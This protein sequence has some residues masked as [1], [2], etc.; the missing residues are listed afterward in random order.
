MFLVFLRS[1]LRCV[2]VCACSECEYFDHLKCFVWG[3]A[4]VCF[5]KTICNRNR[6]EQ[7][8]NNMRIQCLM[9][10]HKNEI[11]HTG[12]LRINI[13]KGNIRFLEIKK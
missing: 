6:A 8:F 1:F 10:T 9:V 7:I 12:P 11:G 5:T 13:K 3:W 2:P 4:S